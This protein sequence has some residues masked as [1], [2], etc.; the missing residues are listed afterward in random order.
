MLG[1]I[2][3][4]KSRRKYRGLE[5]RCMRIIQSDTKTLKFKSSFSQAPQQ[6]KVLSEVEPKAFQGTEK[7]KGSAGLSNDH[8]VWRPESPKNSGTGQQ[9]R[10]NQ[11]QAS[12]C[13]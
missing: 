12:V 10:S 11:S 6:T 2:Q 4:T 3:A 9:P 7:G 5:A 13:I 1:K 8:V